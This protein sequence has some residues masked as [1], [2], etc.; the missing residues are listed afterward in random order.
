MA[1]QAWKARIL[2]SEES[3]LQ[4][5]SGCIMVKEQDVALDVKNG[6]LLCTLETKKGEKKVFME[7]YTY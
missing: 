3:C 5:L 4:E 2:T 7:E 1:L 6:D